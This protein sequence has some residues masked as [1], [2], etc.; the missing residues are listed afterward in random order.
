MRSTVK[1]SSS[2]LA[3]P[4]VRHFFVIVPTLLLT[5][6]GIATQTASSTAGSLQSE[7]ALPNGNQAEA[8]GPPSTVAPKTV[9]TDDG[10]I[11][12]TIDRDG[13]YLVG[14]TYG[15]IPKG[16]Y[17]NSGGTL[18][19]WARLRTLDPKDVIESK[20]TSIPQEVEINAGDTAFLTR[21]C[22]TWQFISFS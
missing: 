16:R 3:F 7:T 4:R 22:G 14:F 17:S 21:N 6:C 20:E 12:F 8:Y 13:T 1:D 5:A 15:D 10:R 19:Y 11:L 18:C 9:I 2:A